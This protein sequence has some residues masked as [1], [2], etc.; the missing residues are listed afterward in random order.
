MP[1]GIHTKL[2]FVAAVLTV[3]CAC[4]VG[5]AAIYSWPDMPATFSVALLAVLWVAAIATA[6]TT[7]ILRYIADYLDYHLDDHARGS[8]YAALSAELE[9]RI[10]E[11]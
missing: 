1:R 5:L 3:P 2:L 8:S 10:R 4:L 6:C 9:R 11:E 7:V